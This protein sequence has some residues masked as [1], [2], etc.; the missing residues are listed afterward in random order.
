MAF[1]KESKDS[2]SLKDNAAD[3]DDFTSID[4]P[5]FK[6]EEDFDS[7][8]IENYPSSASALAPSSAKEPAPPVYGSKVIPL[9]TI[10]A[11]TTIRGILEAEGN[12]QIDGALEGD[13][14]CKASL[15]ITGSVSGSITTATLTADGAA[16]MGNIKSNGSVQLIKGTQVI[17]DITAT[18]ASI[19]GQVKGNMMIQNNV[20]L[21]N[22]ALII[23][24]IVA[25]QIEIKSGAYISGSYQVGGTSPSEDKLFDKVSHL[26]SIEK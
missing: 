24:D 7:T 1:F 23:G 13:I 11:S 8:I 14:I 17:G 9:T 2:I 20:Y 3:I 26:K 12:V 18:D 15:T 19:S 25:S 6:A 5:F 10:P 22:D 4:D 16:I 21:E